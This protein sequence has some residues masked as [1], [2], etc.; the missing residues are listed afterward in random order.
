MLT[1]V[2]VEVGGQALRS[3]LSKFIGSV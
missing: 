3:N 2:I 1:V